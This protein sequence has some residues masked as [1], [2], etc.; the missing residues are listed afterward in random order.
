MNP[1]KK[2][3][4]FAS[5]ATVVLLGLTCLVIYSLKRVNEP[6]A[7]EVSV[8]LYICETILAALTIASWIYFKKNKYE[9]SF[10]LSLVAIF[11]PLLILLAMAFTLGMFF[12]QSINK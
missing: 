7:A 6:G 3:S 4:L 11:P 12:F 1:K 9:V 5:L 10:A 2:A 8:I